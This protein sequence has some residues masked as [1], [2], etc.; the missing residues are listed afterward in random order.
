MHPVASSQVLLRE[1]EVIMD[2][3]VNAPFSILE[4]KSISLIVLDKKSG[5]VDVVSLQEFVVWP[6]AH[7]K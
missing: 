6:A 5:D 4:I 2:A 3:I 1:P 7:R